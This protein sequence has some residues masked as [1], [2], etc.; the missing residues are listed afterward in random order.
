LGFSA[1]IGRIGPELDRGL[2]LVAGGLIIPGVP[3]GCQQQAQSEARLELFRICRDCFAIPLFGGSG[4]ALGVLYVAPVE[5]GSRVVG[6][7][8]EK[9]VQASGGQGVVL[10]FY[11][12]LYDVESIP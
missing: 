5:E 9:D 12:G 11:G 10:R 2:Q 3:F 4:V 1:G 6:M 8:R 7:G